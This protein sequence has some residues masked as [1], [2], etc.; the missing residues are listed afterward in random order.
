[1]F[2]RIIHCGCILK[3]FTRQHRS[4]IDV[5]FILLIYLLINREFIFKIIYRDNYFNFCSNDNKHY[6]NIKEDKE[7]NNEY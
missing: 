7:L 5:N 3:Y 4:D 2:S 6:I 1:M